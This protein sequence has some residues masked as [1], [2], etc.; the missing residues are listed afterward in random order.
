MLYFR[1]LGLEYVVSERS[2]LTALEKS[3][4]I[5]VLDVLGIETF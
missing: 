4:L 1:R 2:C 5:F 3:L